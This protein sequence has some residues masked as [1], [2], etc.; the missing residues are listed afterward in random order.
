MFFFFFFQV[1]CD[2]LVVQ[3]VFG[4]S[5]L[6]VLKEGEEPCLPR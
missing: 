2:L 5:I 1:T 4:G 6:G 3:V